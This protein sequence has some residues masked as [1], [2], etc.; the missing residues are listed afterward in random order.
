M[1][2]WSVGAL[3]AALEKRGML[4]NSIIIFTTD[5]GGSAGGH[6]RSAAS[7]WPLR[8]IKDTVFFPSL[9][10]IYVFYGLLKTKTYKKNV[11]D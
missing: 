8:G 3:V 1:L 9:Y 2:D 10:N 4:D 5:N 6:D 7:N 11:S